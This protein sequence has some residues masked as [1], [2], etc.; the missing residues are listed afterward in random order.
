M[1]Y[2]YDVF[3][4]LFQLKICK[5]KKVVAEFQI[6][7]KIVFHKGTISFLSLKFT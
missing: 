2:K 1:H 3:K 6:D 7:M 4:S 5:N